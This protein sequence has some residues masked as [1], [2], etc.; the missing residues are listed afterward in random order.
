MQQRLRMRC[1]DVCRASRK[2]TSRKYCQIF[3]IAKSSDFKRDGADPWP[4]LASDDKGQAE[5]CRRQL[6]AGATPAIWL[7]GRRWRE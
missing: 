7:P 2:T 5:S 3:S 4:L 1:G 6:P